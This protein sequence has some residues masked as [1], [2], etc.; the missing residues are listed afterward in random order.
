MT[1][2]F[3]TFSIV[4]FGDTVS[5]IEKPFVK[6]QKAL[7]VSMHHT[8]SMN[9][10]SFWTLYWNFVNVF[11]SYLCWC[12]SGNGFQNT[13]SFKILYHMWVHTYISQQVFTCSL[14]TCYYSYLFWVCSAENSTEDDRHYNHQEGIGCWHYVHL[15]EVLQPTE[16]NKQHERGMI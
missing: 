13:A 2:L 11:Q 9:R 7:Y 15:S 10:K 3:G 16:E 5:Q 8:F 12:S 4:Y 1:L 14:V 6:M